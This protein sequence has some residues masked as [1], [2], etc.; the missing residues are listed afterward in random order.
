MNAMKYQVV[1]CRTLK[2]LVIQVQLLLDTGWQLAGGVSANT[3]VFQDHRDCQT[4]ET[5]YYQALV[6]HCSYP[7]QSYSL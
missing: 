5:E 4:I 1:N 2:E 6:F 7:C 3:T